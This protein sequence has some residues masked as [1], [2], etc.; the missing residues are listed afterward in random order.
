MMMT[1][2]EGSDGQLY[3]EAQLAGNILFPE[4]VKMLVG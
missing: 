1:T 2:Q 3:W 4:G